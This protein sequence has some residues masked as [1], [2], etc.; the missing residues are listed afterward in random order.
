MTLGASGLTLPGGI[1]LRHGVKIGPG[2]SAVGRDCAGAGTKGSITGTF[3]LTPT[4]HAFRGPAADNE[5]RL[6]VIRQCPLD[7]DA[8]AVALSISVE[9]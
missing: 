9:N 1:I 4:T 7:D 2:R 3:A 6:Q 8:M 5:I